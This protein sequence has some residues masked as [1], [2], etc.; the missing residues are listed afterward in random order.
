MGK[1]R[2]TLKKISRILS[3][4]VKSIIVLDR[5]F[6]ITSIA[7]MAL[8]GELQTID[9]ELRSDLLSLAKQAND[10][11]RRY[12]KMETSARQDIIHHMSRIGFAPSYSPQLETLANHLPKALLSK[13]GRVW[14]YS[15][16]TYIKDIASGVGR[17]CREAPTG[18]KLFERFQ[19]KYLREVEGIRVQA[20]DLIRSMEYFRASII[21]YIR[22][23]EE[24]SLT[25]PDA[26]AKDIRL[27][28]GSKMIIIKFPYPLPKPPKVPRKRIFKRIKRKI[29]GP[30]AGS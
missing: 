27:T 16:D 7:W 29:I 4:S 22:K 17:D 21:D 14:I 15:Y 24:W 11:K 18:K 5:D 6:P 19:K 25:S 8:R 10:Y 23:G 26:V 20:T 30:E 9:D 2:R 1:E 13:D 12:W 3:D 28:T